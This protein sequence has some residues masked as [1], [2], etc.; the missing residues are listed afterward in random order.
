MAI[1]KLTTDLNNIQVLDPEPNDVGG[2]NAAEFQGKFD[3]A[4]NDIKTYINDTLCVDIDNMGISKSQEL[5]THKISADHDGRYYTETEINTLLNAKTNLT[6]NHLGTWQGFSPVQSDPGIQAVVN[7]NTLSLANIANKDICPEK[8]SSW[9]ILDASTAIN[10]AINIATV[11]G[12]SVKLGLKTYNISNPIVIKENVLLYGSGDNTVIKLNDDIN[13]NVINADSVHHFTLRDFLIDGN[14][15][16][17]SGSSICLNILN[18][19]DTADLHAQIRNVFIKNPKTDGI[20]TGNLVREVRFTNVFVRDD[21]HI[22]TGHCFNIN[23]TDNYFS[24]CG[25]C[26][27]KGDGFHDI[28][29]QNH[30][31]NCKTF[32]C[33][34]NGFL[35]GSASIYSSCSS[36]E[37]G[38]SGF[39][40]NGNANMM[41]IFSADNGRINHNAVEI[42]VNSIGN[43]INLVHHINNSMNGFSD[44]L[45]D[46]GVGAFNNNI[47]ACTNQYSGAFTIAVANYK[48]KPHISNS[49]IINGKNM[50]IHDELNFVLDYNSQKTNN[51]LVTGFSWTSPSALTNLIKTIN[52]D[53]V[54]QKISFGI[55]SASN[56]YLTFNKQFDVLGG[57]RL[58]ASSIF[59]LTAT[60][61]NDLNSL[62]VVINITCYDVGMGYIVEYTSPSG[63]VSNSTELDK[64]AMQFLNLVEKTIPLN[65]RKIQV[66]IMV[67]NSAIIGNCELN[68]YDFKLG[69]YK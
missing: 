6:G 30:Y 62:S 35:V 31:S 32:W 18:S 11:S 63:V 27:V 14:N 34:N 25:G 52:M 24:Q 66:N 23:W 43:N 3:K 47:N 21:N 56:Q 45:L 26:G 37:N 4:G 1:T 19:V 9:N 41:G 49:V 10:D 15:A 55:N 48:T 38:I 20:Y 60:S 50:S 40:V 64:H 8:L 65:T 42:I 17:Q 36:Q 5:A 57:E 67:Q 12:A 46:F 22:A 58:M 33:D 44:F 13:K 16:N 53:N 51:G 54:S 61:L 69:L 59:S 7:A 39:V 2:L 28:G 68:I 29:G